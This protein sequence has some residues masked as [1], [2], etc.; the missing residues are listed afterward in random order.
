MP[1]AAAGSRR[2]GGGARRRRD[3][4][5]RRPASGPARRGASAGRP[6]EQHL[7][8]GLRDRR[9]QRRRGRRPDAAPPD[10]HGQLDSTRPTS[11]TRSASSSRHR[12]TRGRLRRPAGLAVTVAWGLPYFQRY[13]PDAGRPHLPI[14]RRASTPDRPRG[15]SPRPVRFPSDPRGH[16]PRG[17]RRRRPAPQRPPRAHRRG[18]RA[19]RRGPRT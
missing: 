4:R 12:A 8:D 7:L 10:R 3:L 6:P 13:V 18:R 2:N 16:D 11:A 9:G 1:D 17:E 5:A 19:A 15:R 14:D